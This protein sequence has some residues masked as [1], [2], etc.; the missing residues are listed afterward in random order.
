MPA[1]CSPCDFVFFFLDR[2]ELE[3]VLVRPDYEW[4]TNEAVQFVV[5][6]FFQLEKNRKVFID[7]IAT[8]DRRS[9]A[10]FITGDAFRSHCAPSLCEE[11]R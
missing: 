11:M 8:R 9:S 1:T 4:F 2:T 7:P 3:N 5:E 10:P 6:E